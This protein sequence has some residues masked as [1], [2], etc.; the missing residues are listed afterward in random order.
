MRRG[1]VESKPGSE[2]S[3]L[4]LGRQG[5]PDKGAAS[6]G[7]YPF[8]DKVSRRMSGGSRSSI[9]FEKPSGPVDPQQ[10]SGGSSGGGRHIGRGFTETQARVLR[11]M[12]GGSRS[13]FDLGKPNYLLE[14]QERN[15]GSVGDGRQTRRRSDESHGRVSR[16]MSGGSRGSFDLR[17]RASDQS[18][19][20]NGTSFGGGR[21][22][23]QPRAGTR[24]S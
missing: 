18:Y 4:L 24:I 10:R 14:S 11:R 7:S 19:Q 22:T 23:S 21:Q 5:S 2:G 6:R 8:D 9:D 3:S 12:S 13:S 1:S 16:R 15:E 17:S 20:R